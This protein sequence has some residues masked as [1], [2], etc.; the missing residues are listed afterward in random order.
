[1]LMRAGSHLFVLEGEILLF[2][3]LLAALLFPSNTR[4]RKASDSNTDPL[5]ARS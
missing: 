2:A 4:V 1:M 3:L 5:V